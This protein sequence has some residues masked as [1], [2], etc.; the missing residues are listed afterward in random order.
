MFAIRD[1]PAAKI[2]K[3]K[4]FRFCSAKFWFFFLFFNFYWYLCNTKNVENRPIYGIFTK[5]G[6]VLKKQVGVLSP[7]QQKIR[8]W[9]TNIALATFLLP[10]CSVF[11]PF[12]C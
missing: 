8:K 10:L 9:L 1:I 7:R 12:D 6:K 5:I 4:L 11:V 2:A 3:K